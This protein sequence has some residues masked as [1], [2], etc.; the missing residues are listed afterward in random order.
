LFSLFRH[1]RKPLNKAIHKSTQRDCQR[2]FQRSGNDG[3]HESRPAVPFVPSLPGDD[4]QQDQTQS[5]QTDDSSSDCVYHA[6]HLEEGGII[7]PGEGHRT[8]ITWLSERVVDLPTICSQWHYTWRQKGF[9]GKHPPSPWTR[10]SPQSPGRGYAPL[11]YQVKHWTEESRI[12]G[13]FP[14]S[15]GVQLESG[16]TRFSFVFT[17]QAQELSIRGIDRRST[18]MGYSPT[19]EAAPETPTADRFA[20]HAP[21]TVGCKTIQTNGENCLDI[22]PYRRARARVRV[23]DGF[24]IHRLFRTVMLRDIGFGQQSSS[25]DGVLALSVAYDM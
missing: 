23:R 15:A 6:D 17:R 24:N 25:V 5:R 18:S 1:S 13:W 16:Q 11:E 8:A 3:N 14:F 19:L 12:E 7:R 21:L 20:R 9:E 10:T 22:P 2:R 4:C